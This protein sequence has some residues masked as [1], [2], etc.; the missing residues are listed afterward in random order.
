MKYCSEGVNK[1][2]HLPYMFIVLRL[3]EKLEKKSKDAFCGDLMPNY[4]N[5]IN[6]N[7]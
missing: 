6:K 5:I 4:C 3:L 1:G 2:D 7:Y